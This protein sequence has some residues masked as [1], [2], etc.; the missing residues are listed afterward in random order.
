[1]F[2]VANSVTPY[3][4]MVRA[5]EGPGCRGARLDQERMGV[6][7]GMRVCCFSPVGLRLSKG[8][9]RVLSCA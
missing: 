1:M 8:M 2:T 3:A 4:V 5:S 7:A 9:R 6:I